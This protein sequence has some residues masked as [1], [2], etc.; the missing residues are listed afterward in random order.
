MSRM[1]SFVLSRNSVLQTRPPSS[2]AEQEVREEDQQRI[3]SFNKLN[4]RL[5]ELQAGTKAKRV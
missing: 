2:A 5:H 1:S 3:N 4:S